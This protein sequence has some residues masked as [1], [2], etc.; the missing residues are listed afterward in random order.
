MSL[1]WNISGAKRT[2]ELFKPS[3]DSASLQIGNENTF[4]VL[5]FGFF[6][7]DFISSDA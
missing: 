3:K 5:G 7:S 4:L 2:R 6:M 1:H